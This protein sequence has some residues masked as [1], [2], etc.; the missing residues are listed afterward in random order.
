MSQ[1]LLFAAVVAACAA[2]L[3]AQEFPIRYQPEPAFETIVV[4]AVDSMKPKDAFA[5]LEECVVVDARTFRPVPIAQASA[6]LSPCIA[7]VARRYGKTVK[8]DRL[9][10]APEGT[11]S[12]QVEGL[13]IY[14][15]A[16]IAVTDPV[17]RDLQYALS[18]RDGRILGHPVTVRRGAPQASSNK[19]I[20]TPAAL[21][22]S[23][24][25][26][27]VDSCLH[28]LNIRRIETSEDFIQYYGACIVADKQLQVRE[29]RPAAGQPLGVTVQSLADAPTVRSLNGLI[30]VP[31][32][33]GPVI[34]SV[35]AYAQ[36]VAL[37]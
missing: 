18:R 33:K 34:V 24:L 5:G 12:A 11:M 20:T 6:M 16:D 7:A 15:S 21:T 9:A 4:R 22:R 32:A 30:K 8:I 1:T 17:M 27:A 25:Q 19:P 28:T 10:I 31:T 37:K 23:S 36:S 35:V 29:I 3:R 2:P 14:L 13:A 26:G